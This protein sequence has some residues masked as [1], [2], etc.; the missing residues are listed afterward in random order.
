[1]EPS[2]AAMM[3]QC[4]L[5]LNPGEL[6]RAA[7]MSVGVH[8]TLEHHVR[9]AHRQRTERVENG[10]FK[11][12]YY[13]RRRKRYMFE[14]WDRCVFPEVDVFGID[15]RDVALRDF[16]HVIIEPSLSIHRYDHECDNMP[17]MTDTT[18]GDPEFH[19]TYFQWLMLT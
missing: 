12:M 6:L 19:P 2:V 4:W 10:E 5:A 7:C 1:M 9:A 15:D 3:D 14:L 8:S 11:I 13:D 18:P 16:G 17:P